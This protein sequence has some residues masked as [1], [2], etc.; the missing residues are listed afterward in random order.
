MA[1]ALESD[2]S[3][4]WT[5]VMGVSAILKFGLVSLGRFLVCF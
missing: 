1:E 4:T 2:G 5:D 3:P